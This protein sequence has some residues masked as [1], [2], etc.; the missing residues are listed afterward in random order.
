MTTLLKD[1]RGVKLL[2]KKG[3]GN[4]PELFTAFCSINTTRGITFTSTT[5]EFPQIDCDNPDLISWALREKASLSAS[6]AGAGTL[7]TPD[8]QEF[9]DWVTAADSSNCQVVVDVPDT[10]G[11]V[12]FEGAFHCTDFA[13]T[14]NRG[15]KMECTITLQ[16]DGEVTSVPNT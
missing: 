5:N 15:A 3:D 8:V 14:G 12:I 7:N 13:I 6:I 16:S 2:I 4:S 11:G 1:A 9:Y 10:D